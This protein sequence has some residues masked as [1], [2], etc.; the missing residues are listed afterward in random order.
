MRSDGYNNNIRHGDKIPKWYRS[1]FT[2]FLNKFSYIFIYAELESSSNDIFKNSNWKLL[3]KVT[4]FY[5]NLLL[6]YVTENHR[7]CYQKYRILMYI[8]YDKRC[9]LYQDIKYGP[10]NKKRIHR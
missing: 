9:H 8:L 5:V 10:V 7:V 3:I 6:F 2:V 1:Y 4:F